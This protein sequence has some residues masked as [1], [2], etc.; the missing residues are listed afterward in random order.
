MPALVPQAEQSVLENLVQS[1]STSSLL[2]SLSLHLL[3]IILHLGLISTSPTSRETAG[4]SEQ[5]M[6]GAEG[7]LERVKRAAARLS[8]PVQAKPDRVLFFGTLLDCLSCRPGQRNES[9]RG[10]TGA[11]RGTQGCSTNY[12]N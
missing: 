5:G 4:L 8:R 1:V 12:V 6:D 2:P 11:S 7:Q 9:S 3:P 10:V